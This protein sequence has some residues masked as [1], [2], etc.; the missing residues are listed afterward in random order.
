MAGQNQTKFRKTDAKIINFAQNAGNKL[1]P[2]SYPLTLLE[3]DFM[4]Y[5]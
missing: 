5:L 3:K 1:L 4:P 2:I